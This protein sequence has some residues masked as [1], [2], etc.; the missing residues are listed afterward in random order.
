MRN[1]ISTKDLI[2]QRFPEEK[3]QEI[4][5]Q[6]DEEIQEIKWGGKRTGA[7]RKPKGEV[8]PFVRRLNAP[9]N[10]VINDIR[11]KLISIEDINKLKQG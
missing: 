8:R 1:K 3:A 2:K 7:G 11:N 4:I 5:A 6:A 9:E 10:Q